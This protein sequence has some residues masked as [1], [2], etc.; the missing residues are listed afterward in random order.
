LYVRAAEAV[1]ASA[2]R[3]W[4]SFIVDVVDVVDGRDAC[5]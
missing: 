2:R 5:C 1:V 4:R 3:G